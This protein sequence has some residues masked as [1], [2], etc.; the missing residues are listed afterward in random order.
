MPEVKVK[1]GDAD[2]ARAAASPTGTAF[3]V[4]LADRGPTN[5][6]VPITTLRSLVATFGPRVAYSPLYDDFLVAPDQS[7]S[8][9]IDEPLGKPPG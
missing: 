8:F 3:L 6:A 5:V 9:T 2:T 1:V 7:Y 4:T